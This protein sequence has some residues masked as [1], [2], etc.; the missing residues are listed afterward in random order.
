MGAGLNLRILRTTQPRKRV[1]DPDLR[2]GQVF[3]DHMLIMDYTPEGKWHNAR[4]EP[5]GPLSLDPAT[6]VLHYGQ[7]VFDGFKAFRSSTDG[8]VLFRPKDHLVRLNASSARLCIPPVDG[9]FVLDALKQLIRLDADWVPR[10]FGCSLYVRPVI[11]ATEAGLGVRPAK[12]YCFFTILSP[13][14]AY[15]REGFQPV[16]ILVSDKYV[17]S[18]RGG[19]GAAKTPANYAASLLAGE[20]AKAGGFTQVL[21]LD[22]AERTY[23]EEVGTMNIF[24]RMGDSLV[25]PA[26]EGPILGGI[27]RDCVIRLAAHWGIHVEERRI[28]MAE[29]LSAYEAGKLLEVFGSG[30]AAVIS[31]VSELVFQGKSLIINQG[32]IGGWTQRL[33]E[34]V[35]GIQYG[36]MEDPFGWTVPVSP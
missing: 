27:T 25:T 28:S 24:F 2:F 3:T 1:A 29:V 36:K 11:I 19:L 34:S 32:R 30:T 26:L 23:V 12:T 5:Y 35:T 4:I 31:P 18:V 20:E 10:S 6:L 7:A 21:W 33:F 13:V 22:G 8:V 16:R 9:T 15:Y 17:R 14:G